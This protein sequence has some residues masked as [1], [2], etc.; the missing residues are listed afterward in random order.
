MQENNTKQANQGV[1]R[2][3]GQFQIAPQDWKNFFFYTCGEDE[4]Q[5]VLELLKAREYLLSNGEPNIEIITKEATFFAGSL[6]ERIKNRRQAR[7]YGFRKIAA[8][9]QRFSELGDTSALYFYITNVYGMVRWYAPYN[10]QRLP[11]H[12]DALKAYLAVFSEVFVKRLS[13]ITA[14]TPSVSA[15]LTDTL[16]DTLSDTSHRPEKTAKPKRKR[17]A[18]ELVETA[19]VAV[20]EV[21]DTPEVAESLVENPPES[22]SEKEESKEIKEE[23]AHEK[24][25]KSEYRDYRD[26]E[27]E[28]LEYD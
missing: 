1:Q 10:L 5:S 21:G 27:E 19:A 3:N 9:V 4:K 18:L 11:I 24:N 28:G 23:S 17:K 13:E 22:S 6:A 25:H 26:Y 8:N 7:R 2:Q 15:A 20:P 14:N 12:R 16:S